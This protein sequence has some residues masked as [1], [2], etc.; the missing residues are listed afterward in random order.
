[1][2]RWL[3]DEEMQAWRGM[4]DVYNEI[5][6]VIEA[7]LLDTHGLSGGEYGV[8]VTLSEA[9]ERQLRMCDLAATLHVSPS[10]LTRR[11]DRL[12]KDG[13]VARESAPDDRRVTLAVLT[14]DGMAKLRSA[15]PDHVECVRRNFIDQL[16]RTQIRQLGAA[17]A[18]VMERRRVPAAR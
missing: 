4:V 17:L 3:D 8:L 15:A 10:G 12:V 16:T 11:I 5:N 18:S 13:L 7:D 1:M 9:P 2:T 6:A 14:D